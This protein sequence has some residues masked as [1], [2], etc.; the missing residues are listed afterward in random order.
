MEKSHLALFASLILLNFLSFSTYGIPITFFPNVA[1]TRGISGI[2]VGLIFAMYPMGAFCCGLIVGKMLTKW[3]RKRVIIFSQILMGL[4]ILIFG[5]A[6]LSDNN[7]VFITIAL[8]TR[9]TQ[10]I[11]LG[12][13]QTAAYAFVPEYWP[14]EIDFRIGLLEVT[15][16][17]GIGTGPL[18]GALIYSIWGYLAIYILPGVII[19]VFG[20]VLAYFTLP[21]NKQKDQNEKEETLSLKKSF[22]HRDMVYN[23]FVLVVN[24]GGFTLIMPD[25]ENKVISIGGSPQIASILFA[26]NQVGYI[27]GIALLMVY[28]V[29]NRKGIFFVA[30]LLS[31]VSLLLLGIDTFVLISDELVLVL[32]GMGTFVSGFVCAFSLVPFVSES[33]SILHSIFPEKKSEVLDNMA[34]GF[35][36]AAISLAEFHGPLLGG[37]LSENFGFSKGCLFYAIGVFVFFIIHATHGEGFKAVYEWRQNGRKSMETDDNS[38]IEVKFLENNNIL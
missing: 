24:Y 9:A 28:K 6:N 22:S 31:I 4:S 25:L 32:I 37:Y 1:E 29:K 38:G 16:G 7:S 11:A 2:L 34:S 27:I 30:W 12:S 3:E 20:S 18:I 23:F 13:C 10:G 15:V 8:V 19:M 35:F 36:T 5:M 21:L 14:E 33:I 17:F 26:C